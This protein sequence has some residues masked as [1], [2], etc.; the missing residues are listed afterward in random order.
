MI[1]RARRIDATEAALAAFAVAGAV[2]FAWGR[3]EPRAWLI[4]LAFPPAVAFRLTAIPP[5]LRGAVEK[6]AWIT[7]GL[8]AATVF[9]WLASPAGQGQ[10]AP[11]L[12]AAA[13]YAGPLLSAFFLAGR[14]VWPA[15]R[16]LI[17]A[18]L[19]TTVL[20]ASQAQ[21][22]R[23][24][25]VTVGVVALTGVLVLLSD[26]GYGP[27]SVRLRRVVRLA[28]FVVLAAGVAIGISRLLP[29]AQPHVVQAAARAAFP[30]ATSGFSPEASLGGSEELKLSSEVVLRAWSDRPRKLRAWVATRFDGARWL[31]SPGP[32]LSV[33]GSSWAPPGE[34]AAW[35]DELRGQTF[36]LASPESAAPVGVRLERTRI[37]LI[38]P[39]PGSIPRRPASWPC[40]RRPSGLRSMGRSYS[41]QPF[42]PGPSMRS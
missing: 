1:E 23:D 24:M 30:E 18:V 15:W 32:I 2:A 39:V 8:L 22:A 7:L 37:L 21:S 31:P 6:A 29:W 4:L 13:C 12:P 40:A 42:P 10:P 20:G 27:A 34:L 17:P 9:S 33:P 16:A 11:P 25:G 35:F 5:R 41:A 38:L 28:V 3:A 19:I 14:S 36:L 26:E